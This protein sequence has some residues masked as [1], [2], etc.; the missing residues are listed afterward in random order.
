M[1]DT[2]QLLIACHFGSVSKDEINHFIDS[3]IKGDEEYDPMIFDAYSP[4][5]RIGRRKLEIFLRKSLPGF[6]VESDEGVIACRRELKHQI[7]RLSR[8][9]C[10]QEEFCEFFNRL[11]NELVINHDVPVDFFGDLF[12][13]CDC[14]DENWRFLPSK[15]LEEESMRVLDRITQAE[16]A[17]APNR[18]LPPTLN[19]TSSVRSSEDS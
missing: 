18:S 10:S 4:D 9:E 14:F 19:S 2:Q 11:E 5:I 12:N 3:M 8:N 7:E 15:Y 17:V 16:L 13:A 1:R 6:E